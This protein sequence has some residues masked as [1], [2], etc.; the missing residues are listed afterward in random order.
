LYYQVG[1]TDTLYNLGVTF[2]VAANT[3]GNGYYL[4]TPTNSLYFWNTTGT[5][6]VTNAWSHLVSTWDGTSLTF[7]VN[8]VLK[9]TVITNS[10]PQNNGTGG[11]QLMGS[12]TGPSISGNSDIQGQFM[13][14]YVSVVRIYS[15]P[16]TATQINQNY[17]AELP[18][19]NH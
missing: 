19:F 8:G 1:N 13:D 2:N 7:Y 5:S 18:R 9:S 16:L 4:N 15:T 6:L 10:I 17:N 11:V 12:F 3:F 14:G